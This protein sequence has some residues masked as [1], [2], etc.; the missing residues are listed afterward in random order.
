MTSSRPLVAVRSSAHRPDGLD[1][2]EERGPE[3]T[4]T[5]T[6]TMATATTATI[7]MPET[8][9]RTALS[10]P[11]EEL[12]AILGGRGRARLA[13][14]CYSEG[15]DPHYLF[16]PTPALPAA[17]SS[18]GNEYVDVDR[19]KRMVLP[20]PRRTQVLGNSALDLLSEMHSHCNGVIEGG[21]A[22]LVHVRS[23]FDGT[24]KL[25]LRLMDGLEVETV[26][27]PFWADGG[28]DDDRTN[29][30]DDVFVAGGGG[31]GT[32]GDDS[33][34]VVPGRTTVC[35][36]SQVGCRQG[37]TFCATG[38]M[39]KLRSL[40][41]DEILAQLFFAR[42]VVR[43]SRAGRPLDDI[44]DGGGT[45]GS[46]TITALPRI[47]NVVFMGMGEPSD[48]AEAVRA[49]IDVMT[50]NDLF[51]LSASR[52]TVSTV[53]PTPDSF[54]EFAD[55]RCVLA[56]SV[57]AARDDLRRRLVPTTR[58]T[59]A[60][61]RDGLMDALRRRTMR[62]CMIEVA[63]M[64]GVNDSTREAE[65]MAEFLSYITDNVPGSKVACNLIPYNDIG[66]IGVG[67]SKPSRERIV[68]FQKRMQEL[69]VQAHVRGTRGDD[70]SAACGQLVTSRTRA[71]QLN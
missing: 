39:G 29:R 10:M 58:Y 36:S 35:V 3:T 9:T 4:A 56:W 16:G 33:A 49:A 40:T 11:L 53:A 5:K 13:W 27:I 2:F 46:T 7:T 70:E 26:L 14:D 21:L 64:D 19:V 59:M 69:G 65:E 71:V 17:S 50:R 66:S 42:K 28:N 67:Y 38:K 55:A 34:R 1:V 68:A 43:L 54:A 61:L 8:H 60:E 30:R 37:C 32:I 62:T 45:G 15:A 44:A 51:Q 52:V 57:H 12:S 18:I 20:T 24:T 23:S 31:G 6:T 48:N 25:L 47:T 41:S 22:T 63:L